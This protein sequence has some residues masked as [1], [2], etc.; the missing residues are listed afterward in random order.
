MEDAFICERLGHCKIV[1]TSLRQLLTWK[2][3]RLRSGVRPRREK[4]P[5]D[6]HPLENLEV[7][8]REGG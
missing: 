3:S 2:T 6:K 4:R 1:A 7:L 5:V 8:G